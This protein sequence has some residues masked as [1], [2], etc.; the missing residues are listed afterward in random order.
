MNRKKG[1]PRKYINV[2]GVKINMF[3][4]LEELSPIYKHRKVKVICECGTIKNINLD[5]LTGK[6]NTK[7]CGCLYNVTSSKHNL[8]KHPLYGVWNDIKMRCYNKNRASY[9]NYGGRGVL[10]YEGWIKDFKAFYNWCIENGWQNG[11]EIDKDIKGDGLLYSP[12]TCVFVSTKENSNTRRNSR[13][14]FY[15]GDKL[16]IAQ[17]ADMLKVPYSK[18]YF[19]ITKLGESE[20]NSIVENIKKSA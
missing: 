6:T 11:L 1:C 12:E 14:I 5:N 4:I 17:I 16:T 10:M 13:Y 19:Q 15:M 8:S 7:S 2:V 18:V 3:T 9:K 20:I